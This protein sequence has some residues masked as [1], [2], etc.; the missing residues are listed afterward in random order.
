MLGITLSHCVCV[1]RAATARGISLGGEGNV[2][3]L[4]V[5]SFCCNFCRTDFTFY[6]KLF[7][8]YFFLKSAHQRNPQLCMCVTI[9]NSRFSKTP[10][11]GM[12]VQEAMCSCQT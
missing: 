8:K 9:L 4:L 5:S 7:F 2:L 3:Y 6:N 11:T 12:H 10:D 1:H